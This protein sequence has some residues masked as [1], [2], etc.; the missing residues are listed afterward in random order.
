MG[1]DQG[2]Q[3]EIVHQTAREAFADGAPGGEER[4]VGKAYRAEPVLHPDPDDQPKDR[5]VQM[6]VVVGVDVIE[7][8]NGPAEALELG[9]HLGLELAPDRRL[10]E[11]SEP[12]PY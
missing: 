8:K 7:R 11:E 3:A 6:Y 5:W 2:P 12:R 9:A 4:L 1:E 10:E